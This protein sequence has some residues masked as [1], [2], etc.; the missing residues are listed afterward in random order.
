MSSSVIQTFELKKY[1]SDKLFRTPVVRS[2]RMSEAPSYGTPICYFDKNSKGAAA[3]AEV[4][5]EI[6]KRI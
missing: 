6:L 4:T 1:Y 2:V 3:Y 5:S